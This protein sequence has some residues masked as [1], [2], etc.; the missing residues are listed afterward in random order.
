MTPEPVIRV[1]ALRKTYGRT[2]AVDGVSF[3]AGV[4][5]PT[6][7]PKAA[8]AAT[9]HDVNFCMPCLQLESAA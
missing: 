7:S 2:V 4:A 1:D 9:T 5:A 8:L 6:P 3:A